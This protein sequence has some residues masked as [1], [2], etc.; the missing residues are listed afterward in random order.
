G[1]VNILED[2]F[3]DREFIEFLEYFSSGIYENTE[4][5]LILNGDFFNLLMIDFE[6]V[7]PEI[8]TELIAL[9]RM[10]KI[11]DGH[12]ASMNALRYFQSLELKSVTFVMGNHDP[13]I[14]FPSVQE[15]I[16]A[17]V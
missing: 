14:L 11:I 6:E 5:E 15:L 8:V 4:V 1:S 17:T 16:R 9:R 7:E 2:F 3:H 13:G 12:R 10:K